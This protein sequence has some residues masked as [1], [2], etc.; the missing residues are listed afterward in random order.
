M[1]TKKLKKSYV[2]QNSSS[3]SEFTVSMGHPMIFSIC[4][5]DTN[6]KDMAFRL[7]EKVNHLYRWQCL[8]PTYWLTHFINQI[9]A[10]ISLWQMAYQ[11][12]TTATCS[13]LCSK[14][15]MW[16]TLMDP[17][18]HQNHYLCISSVSSILGNFLSTLKDMYHNTP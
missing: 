9:I 10:H 11:R 7:N 16:N 1:W 13:H 17:L 3:C 5:K 8:L 14:S 4:L 12:K 2:M 18:D 15:K 6:F